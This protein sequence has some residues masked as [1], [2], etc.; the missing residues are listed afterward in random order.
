VEVEPAVKCVV[1]VKQ[2]A[3][4]DE[5]FEIVGGVAV[6]PDGLE[7]ALNEWDEFSLEA[8]LDLRD[9]DGGGEVVVVSVGD[10]EADQGLH[11]CLAKGADRAVR[12]WDEELAGADAL[13]VARVLAA[14]VEREQPDLVLCG[15]QS[16][17]AVN[18]ATGVALAANLG[19]PWVA[20]VT[21]IEVG[22]GVAT[23]ARELEGGVVEHLRL[24]LPAVLTVQTGINEPRYANLRA[25]KQAR[26]KPFERLDLA[27]VGLTTAD[28]A[29]AAGSRVRRLAAPALTGN[30]E[31]LNG[32]PE[33]VAERIAEIL[34]ER[35]QA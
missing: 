18:A 11:T 7:W 6:D 26:E 16:S 12:L 35:L 13:A 25:I 24:A 9:A 5:E 22:D 28:V 4:L 27:A 32:S 3:S 30:A 31:M 20:V 14:L 15:A 21:A 29:A 34:E 19:L 2:V 8:A 10:E 1:P 33:S 17:D 23:V